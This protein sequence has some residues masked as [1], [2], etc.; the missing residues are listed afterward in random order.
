MTVAVLAVSDY[1]SQQDGYT[2]DESGSL[3]QMPSP[4][5]AVVDLT[6]PPALPMSTAQQ[7]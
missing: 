6:R 5:A 2:T 3:E 7:P 1:D 4:R